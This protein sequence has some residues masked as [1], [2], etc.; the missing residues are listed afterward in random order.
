M[1]RFQNN[2][3]GH[4][5]LFIC[6]KYLDTS[7][8]YIV[9]GGATRLQISASGNTLAEMIYIKAIKIVCCH[10]NVFPRWSLNDFH[11]DPSYIIC[12]SSSKHFFDIFASLHAQ[13]DKLVLENKTELKKILLIKEISQTSIQITMCGMYWSLHLKKAVNLFPGSYLKKFKTLYF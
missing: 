4:W 7:F 6:E 1:L 3:F 11:K 8:G 9:V 12:L 5:W 2:I 13:T 10:L